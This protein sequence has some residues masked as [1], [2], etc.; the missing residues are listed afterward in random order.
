MATVGNCEDSSCDDF[1]SFKSG[2]AQNMRPWDNYPSMGCVKELWYGVVC[3]ANT[4]RISVSPGGTGCSSSSSNGEYYY[5]QL[6]P[7]P[8]ATQSLF[9]F[10]WECFDVDGCSPQDFAWFPEDCNPFSSALHRGS[11]C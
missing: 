6:I 8:R 3:A 10:G 7:D 1:T 4:C 5:G 9:D 2:C 11:C